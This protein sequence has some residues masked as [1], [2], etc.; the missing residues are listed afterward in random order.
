MTR[1]PWAACTWTPSN[2]AASHTTAAVAKRS[3]MSVISA[4]VSSRGV[5]EPGRLNGTALGATG[6]WPIANGFDWRPG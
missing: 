5:G 1:Y 4:P 3:M 2:P 6:T